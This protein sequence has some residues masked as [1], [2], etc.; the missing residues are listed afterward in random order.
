MQ[1]MLV[2][3]FIKQAK[4]ESP[5]QI[6]NDIWFY[7]IKNIDHNGSYYYDTMSSDI[8]CTHLIGGTLQS[9]NSVLS[10][11][12]DGDILSVPDKFYTAIFHITSVILPMPRQAQQK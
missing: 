9:I 4:T 5:G 8:V 7:L 10:Y 12:I 11:I 6:E 3:K 1:L 2:A